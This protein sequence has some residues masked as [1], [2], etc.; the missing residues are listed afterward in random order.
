MWS[1]MSR[2]KNPYRNKMNT[3]DAVGERVK[4]IDLFLGC[5]VE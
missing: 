5:H 2:K 3:Y 1:D 4:G